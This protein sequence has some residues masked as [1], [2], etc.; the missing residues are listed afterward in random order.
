[1]RTMRIVGLGLCLVLL[2]SCKKDEEVSACLRLEGT[3][4]CESWQED[5]Q[6]FV[7]DTAFITGAELTFKKLTGSQGDYTLDI[8]YLIG[9]D[10]NI[11]GAYVV[12][13]DC[14]EVVITPKGGSAS[15]Y[16]FT[17]NGD[18]LTLEGTNNAILFD[19]Q[20]RKQ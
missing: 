14:D 2:F 6:E 20:F 10:E 1:M 8:H 11:I 5:G 18:M 17:V 15:T 9:G 3:W 12:N 7:G 13:T 16:A 4:T 19:L